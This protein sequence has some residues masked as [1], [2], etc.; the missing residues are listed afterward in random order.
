[1]EFLK[2]A[3]CQKVRWG[4]KKYSKSLSWTENLNK[5][6]T[7]MG[8]KF[9]LFAQDSDLEY[10]F[11]PHQSFWQKAT[12]SM[13]VSIHSFAKLMVENSYRVEVTFW[14]WSICKT[15]NTGGPCVMPKFWFSE[16]VVV[17]T[18]R[19]KFFMHVADMF[20]TNC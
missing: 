10:F 12:F 5:L 2:A 4:S 8:G 14:Q 17:S 11:E 18:Y 3:F 19:L 13:R 1:M 9:K 7:V 16:K 6:F 15:Q 20:L